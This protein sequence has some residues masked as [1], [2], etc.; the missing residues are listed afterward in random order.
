MFGLF[1]L[2]LGATLWL[3][4]DLRDEWRKL[5]DIYQL[6]LEERGARLRL[7]ESERV[8]SGASPTM[9]PG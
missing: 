9:A 4:A 2:A 3:S 7:R 1:A 6:Q 8:A 5:D